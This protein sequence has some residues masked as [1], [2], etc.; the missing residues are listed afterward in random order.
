MRRSGRWSSP[1]EARER[2]GRQRAHRR[3]GDAAGCLEFRV[4]AGRAAEHRRLVYRIEHAEGEARRY[5]E[6]QTGLTGRIR[7]P[8]ERS[9][10][11]ALDRAEMRVYAR[12]RD[13][14]HRTR[15]QADRVM[16]DLHD[17]DVEDH[18]A[19]PQRRPRLGPPRLPGVAYQPSGHLHRDLEQFRMRSEEIGADL[20]GN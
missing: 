13:Q 7:N 4:P 11:K 2:P 20:G 6:I 9:R 10:A 8:E 5:F 16:N 17:L 19:A 1:D 14:A 3:H 15:A 18:Q 12:W